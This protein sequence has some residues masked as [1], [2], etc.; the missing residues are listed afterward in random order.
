MET[1]KYLVRLYE[2]APGF[3][4]DD[5]DHLGN[6][7]ARTVGELLRIQFEAA[8]MR[9]SRTVKE[10]L[11]IRDNETVTPKDLINARTVTTVIGSFFGSSQL[12][13]FLDETN[14]LASLT[15]KRRISALGPGGLSR[16]RAGFE[17]RDVHHSH[18]GRFCPIETPEGPNIGLIS[19]LCTY[20][21]FNKYGFLETPYFLV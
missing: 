3:I 19:S 7:R 6:R 8:F 13:Q 12:S 9:L 4:L 16:E 2:A 17:V 18:Y 21:K 20:A 5:I 15:H 1:V 14:P 10:R 11:A